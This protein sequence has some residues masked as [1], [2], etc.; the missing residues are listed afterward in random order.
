[1]RGIY[2]I[3]FGGKFYIGRASN[4]YKRALQHEQTINGIIKDYSAIKNLGFNES[5]YAKKWGSYNDIATYLLENP[6]IR[7]GTIEVIQRCITQHDLYAA[8][9]PII[10]LLERNGDCWNKTF[11]PQKNRKEPLDSWNVKKVGGVLYYFDESEPN[12]LFPHTHNISA[13]GEIAKKR[14]K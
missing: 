10:A 6:K 11:N 3:R 8:E 13:D 14:N 1:M 5:V 4:M 12:K 9:T 2:K 7:F